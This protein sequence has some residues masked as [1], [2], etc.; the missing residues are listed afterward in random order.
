MSVLGLIL[1]SL[2]VV[3]VNVVVKLRSRSGEGKDQVGLHGGY[4]GVFQ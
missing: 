1:K 2:L 4:Q 3:V